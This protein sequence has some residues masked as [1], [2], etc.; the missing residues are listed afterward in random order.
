MYALKVGLSVLCSIS[1]FI[2]FSYSLGNFMWDT[3]NMT[4]FGKEMVSPA[5]FSIALNI[6]SGLL[7]LMLVGIY[8][9]HRTR[10]ITY[11]CSIVL[12]V[13]ILAIAPIWI[14]SEYYM[15]MNN[16]LQLLVF[17][18]ITAL[19]LAIIFYLMLNFLSRKERDVV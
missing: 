6:L 5:G 14:M 18:S 4:L 11:F 7:I 8:T 2:Y 9:F 1:I 13:T 15:G 12:G 3:S 10:P 19:V 17:N 16:F